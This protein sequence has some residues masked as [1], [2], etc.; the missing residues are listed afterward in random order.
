M[1][2]PFH[3]TESHRVQQTLAGFIFRREVRLK[4][5]AEELLTRAEKKAAVRRFAQEPVLPSAFGQLQEV[6]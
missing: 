4:N 3:M 1:T 5:D 2:T 6:R